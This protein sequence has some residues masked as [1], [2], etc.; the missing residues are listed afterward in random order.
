MSPYSSSL[1]TV[2]AA[3]LVALGACSDHTDTTGTNSTTPPAQLQCDAGN[4]GITLPP[5]FCAV[6]VADLQTD[7]KP[8]AARHMAVTPHGDVFVAIN[9]PSSS[10][11]TFGIIAVRDTN[12]DGHSDVQSQFSPGLGGSGI[13]WGNGV[14]YFGANDRV[15]RY[16]MPDGQLTP[17]G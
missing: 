3:S 7:G 2:F 5:G 10:N 13:A 12:G 11:P 14:L 1:K 8:A 6:V 16:P 9:N 4:G 15:V 17:A